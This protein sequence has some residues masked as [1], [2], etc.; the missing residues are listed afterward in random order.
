MPNPTEKD[1]P[2]VF[3]G[4][5][6]EKFYRNFVGITGNRYVETFLGHYGPMGPDVK[7]ITDRVVEIS[8][9]SI[10]HE[11]QSKEVVVEVVSPE[12]EVPP[13]EVKWSTTYIPTPGLID[14]ILKARTEIPKSETRARYEQGTEANYTA[15]DEVSDLTFE[16]LKTIVERFNKKWEKK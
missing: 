3:A 8:R 16:K 1:F 6:Q 13:S 15:F 10:K 4:A 14:E 5:S 2:Y 9:E 12:S 7:N 11:E